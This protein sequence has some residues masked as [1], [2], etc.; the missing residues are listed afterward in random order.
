[1]KDSLGAESFN[2]RV[3]VFER[4]ILNFLVRVRLGQKY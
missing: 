4:I 1:M 3:T 2:F